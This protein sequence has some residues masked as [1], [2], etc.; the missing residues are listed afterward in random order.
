MMMINNKETLVSFPLY[1]NPLKVFV[2]AAVVIVVE[3][4]V[5]VVVPRNLSIVFKHFGSEI[6]SSNK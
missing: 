3:D 4:D 2:V 6:L 5:V 1:Q